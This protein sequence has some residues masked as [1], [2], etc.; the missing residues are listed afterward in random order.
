MDSH[1]PAPT[2]QPSLPRSETSSLCDSEVP[3]QPLPPS[4]LGMFEGHV[5]RRKHFLSDYEKY[6]PVQNMQALANHVFGSSANV[7]H[8]GD[9]IG[10]SRRMLDV[11]VTCRRE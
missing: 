7:H 4:Q 2:S 11:G 8:I 9:G 10:A 1:P 5:A 3:T 6:T